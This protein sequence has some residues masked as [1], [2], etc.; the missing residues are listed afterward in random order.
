MTTHT[1]RASGGTT[2]AEALIKHAHLMLANCGVAMSPSKVS[3]LVRQFR[4]RVEQNGF[5]FEAFLVNAV[6]MTVEQRS[7]ALANPEIARV[8][9]YAD[10]TGETAVNRVMGSNKGVRHERTA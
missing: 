9:A 3:R 7:K 6:Q 10:P 2:S 8:I 4:N 1:T 5:L